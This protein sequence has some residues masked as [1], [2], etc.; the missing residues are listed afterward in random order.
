M[1]K[2]TVKQ[3]CGHLTEH[4]LYGPDRGRHDRLDWLRTVPC[5]D[6]KHETE[7]A[8]ATQAATAAGLPTLVGS[9]KQV[10]WALTIR[11]KAMAEVDQAI[12]RKVTDLERRAGHLREQD[13]AR[14]DAMMASVRDVTAEA[15]R[16][17]ASEPAARVWIDGRDH[18]LDAYNA[19]YAPLATTAQAA[20][21]AG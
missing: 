18:I 3:S 20:L 14:Y 5:L 13:A 1:A 19:I 12:A 8:A 4:Q 10:A 17:F 11:A 16:R 2:Y 21:R 9:E 6:C 7:R 15:R